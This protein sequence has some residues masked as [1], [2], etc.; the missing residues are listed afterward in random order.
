M[1]PARVRVPS[2]A[3]QPAASSPSPPRPAPGRVLV[4]EDE[5]ELLEVLKLVL[6]D[7]GHT[8]VAAKLGRAAVQA[9]A[10]GKFDV[11]VLDMSMPDV[12]GIEVAQALRAN[13]D[14][15]GMRIAIHTALGESWVRER[16]TD[17]DL[18]LPKVDDVDVLT[19]AIARL[20]AMPPHGTAV[21]AEPVFR[22]EHLAAAE[23]M[24][25][26][27]TGTAEAPLSLARFVSLLRD[28]IGHATGSG[29]SVADVAAVLS[30]ATGVA[31]GEADLARHLPRPAAAG[32]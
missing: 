4:V 20:V 11:A 18:F 17:Y 30:K 21:A 7:E 3:M 2:S 29:R 31:V 6:E 14:T 15:A 32:E 8:V 26:D 23:R 25:R 13:A 27:A 9:A 16:F 28:E 19:R 10:S 5:D 1:A 12:S 22:F 24:L